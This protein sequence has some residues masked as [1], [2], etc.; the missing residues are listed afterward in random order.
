[1]S[2]PA[3]STALTP[4]VRSAG[5]V[6]GVVLISQL[7]V[8]LDATIVNIAL[9][10]ISTALAFSP[11]GLSWVINAYTLV[12]GGLLLLGARAGDVLGRRRVFLAGIAIFTV[13]SLVGGLAGTAAELLIARAAQGV[14]AAL[15][16]P[17]ALALLMTLFP[18]AKERAKA[19]GYYTAVSIGGSALGLIVGGML[20][21]WT[22]WRWVLFINVPIGIALLVAARRVIP[23]TPRRPGRF[24]LAGAITATFG[25]ATLVYSL[26]RVGSDGW[27]DP[28]AL[29]GFG[30]AVVLLATFVAVERR[31]SSPIT[32]LRLFSD[33]DRVTSYVARLLLV[34]GMMGMFFFLTQF[35]QNVLGYSPVVTG[36]A[37]LPLTIA[38]FTM[39]QL[40]AR[41]LI[42]RIG[43]KA[44]IAGGLT[45]S[46][47][48]LFWLSDLSATSG[49]TSLLFPILLF[50]IGNGLAFVPLTQL[51]LS[52]VEPQD[53]GAASGLVNVTQQI[54]GALGL[55]ILVTVFAQ[56]AGSGYD[57]LAAAVAGGTADPAVIAQAHEA[58]VAGAERAFG[59]AA[60]FL[61]VT[62][63]LVL[64]LVRRRPRPVPVAAVEADEHAAVE[65]ATA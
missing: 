62:V 47:G 40:T 6:L 17:S 11:T 64:A 59:W 12:F 25:T 19:L 52:G 39:S 46:T 15:A 44:L 4:K 43:A 49:Y 37:F 63:V 60:G 57:R 27:S 5:L 8:V 2:S 50:G 26:V 51:A 35:L 18:E 16:A 9:P 22:S 3:L 53:A 13:A 33:R 28:L 41:M 56:A 58:F 36:L 45:V 65:V 32:P 14:G 48:G 24:D 61:A 21:Q 1:M 38:L 34:A 10:D 20:T 30:A 23:E 7:M 42:Q 54:G 29:S 55:A 31:A